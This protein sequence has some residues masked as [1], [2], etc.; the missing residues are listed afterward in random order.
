MEA[1]LVLG[2]SAALGG[3]EQLG[4]LGE[5]FELGA[6]QRCHTFQIRVFRICAGGEE[7]SGGFEGADFRRV[8]QRGETGAVGCLDGGAVGQEQAEG[9][10]A[11]VYGGPVCE[12]SDLLTGD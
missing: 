7:D 5:P 8:M 2:P 4:E 11:I 1:R 12:P 9:V 3:F 10:H 6:S